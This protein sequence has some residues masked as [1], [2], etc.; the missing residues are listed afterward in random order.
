M[1]DELLRIAERTYDCSR[2]LDTGWRGEG[3]LIGDHG[4]QLL[5]GA[6]DHR[7]RCSTPPR[8]RA[9]RDVRR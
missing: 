4:Y 8:K 7:P 6:C 3:S 9:N 2:C 1:S 5:G